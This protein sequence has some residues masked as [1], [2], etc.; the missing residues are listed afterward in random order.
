MRLFSSSAFVDESLFKPNTV[1]LAP[2]RYALIFIPLILET[3][4][5]APSLLILDKSNIFKILILHTVY[6]RLVGMVK[7]TISKTPIPLKYI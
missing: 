2:S 3:R 5:T 4:K 6:P 7:K 1:N